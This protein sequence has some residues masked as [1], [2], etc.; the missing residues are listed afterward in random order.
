[1]VREGLFD[2]V[3]FALHWHPAD[4]NSA[5]ARTTLANRSAKFRFRGLSAHA[6]GAP[7]A[8]PLGPRRRR[9]DELHGQPA[10]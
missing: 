5:A 7:G 3:D 10:A 1:M 2:D 9:G 4:Q 8:R 6:A